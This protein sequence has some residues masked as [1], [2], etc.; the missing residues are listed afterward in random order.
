MARAGDPLRLH[1]IIWR[2]APVLKAVITWLKTIG[3]TP[4]DAIPLS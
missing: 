2:A 3:D 4:L 1:A